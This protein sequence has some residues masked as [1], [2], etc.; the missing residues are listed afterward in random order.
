MGFGLWVLFDNQSFIAVLRKC[1]ITHTHTL[2]PAAVSFSDNTLISTYSE[3]SAHV[4]S[5]VL[6]KVDVEI[7]IEKRVCPILKTLAYPAWLM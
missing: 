2:S 3:L 4:S 1:C 7:E 6:S 5:A